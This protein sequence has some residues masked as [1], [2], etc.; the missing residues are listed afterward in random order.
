MHQASAF[1]PSEVARGV[2]RETGLTHFV[3]IQIGVDAKTGEPKVWS[4]P[5][6]S[7]FNII[8]LGGS[9]AGKTHSIHHMA[10]NVYVRGTT[11]H[12]I[13]IKGDFAHSNFEATGL[14]HMLYPDDFNEIKFNYYA[15]GCSLNP[16]QVPRTEEGGGVVRT[17]EY[18]K[19]LVKVF[20]PQA[21]QKQLNYLIAIL[22]TV[23]LKAGIDHDDPDSWAKPS[24]TLIDVLNE[25]DLIFSA[26]TGGMDTTTVADIFKAFGQARNQADK[27]I[28]KMK[29]E[30]EPNAAIEER[31]QEIRD[32]LEVTLKGHVSKLINYNALT[33][34]Q[35]AR[36]DWEHW[37]KETLFSLKAII[38]G[39]VDSRLFTGNPSKPRAGKINRYD[40]TAL[41]PAHQQVIM[42]IIAS[43][44]FAMGVMETKRNNSFNPKYPSH[45]LIADEGKH[46]KEISASP[47]SPFNRIGTEGRGYGVGVWCGVQ[48]PDQVT[49]DLLKNF[50]TFFLLKTPDA[51]YQEITKLFGVRPT[52]LKSL[53]PRENL[54]FGTGGG[55]TLVNHFR[56]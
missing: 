9:G 1:A 48:Q 34:R 13:D 20:N 11:L 33:N 2:G 49:K 15:D 53:Q 40:L 38:Q 35:G 39:M 24:P 32:T 36:E 31:V 8:F 54:L 37:S 27:D 29:M 41:S 10:A 30:E 45:I 19:E 6:V 14:G 26:L 46:I 52:L 18:V 23:Y 17:I 42:R 43:Q 21:G 55:Y 4:Y 7:N 28:R 51:S 25:I 47:I 5:S 56:G 16:L 12:V 44:V 50:A 22:K 3:E